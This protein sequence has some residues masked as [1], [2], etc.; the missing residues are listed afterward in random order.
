MAF[1]FI[2]PSH[3]SSSRRENGSLAS[4]RD[5]LAQNAELSIADKERELAECE[6]KLQDAVHR[7]HLQATQHEVQLG[8]Y[9]G[10][11]NMR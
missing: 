3:T 5:Q 10:S 4:E 1:D 2:F 6:Q 8:H 11:V 7:I 9:V